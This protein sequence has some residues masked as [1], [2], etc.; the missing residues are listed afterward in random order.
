VG[1]GWRKLRNFHRNILHFPHGIFV[2]TP[3]NKVRV[4]CG[5]I[6]ENLNPREAC[7]GCVFD[8][9]LCMICS[10]C[11]MFDLV[12]MHTQ[13]QCQLES[14][15]AHEILASSEI[16]SSQFNYHCTALCIS[17]VYVE[18]QGKCHHADN[19]HKTLSEVLWRKFFTMQEGPLT[20]EGPP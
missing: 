20:R 13:S 1:L 5:S 10:V 12:R 16:G 3:P 17:I 15:Y 2:F 19:P 8:C 6:C 9:A 7:H 4:C 11:S 14:A 18:S